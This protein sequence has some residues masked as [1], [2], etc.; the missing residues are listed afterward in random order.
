MK[1]KVILQKDIPNLGVSGELTEVS[2]G[3]ARNYLLPHRMAVVASDRALAQWQS[4]KEKVEK[5]KEEKRLQAQEVAKKIEEI[6]CTLT[7]RAGEDGKLFGSVTT[8]EISKALAEKGFNI[9]RRWI[10]VKEPVK[11]TG[12]FLASVRLHSKVSATFKLVVQPA[13]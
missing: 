4:Q 1:V 7:A 13:G 3:Y 2:T 6:T 8:G 9:D 11:T 5:E 10:E 12:S